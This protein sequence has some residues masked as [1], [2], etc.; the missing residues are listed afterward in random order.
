M[1]CLKKAVVCE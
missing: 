1:H